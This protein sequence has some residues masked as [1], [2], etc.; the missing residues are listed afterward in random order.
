MEV[1][2]A[3]VGCVCGKIKGNY[4]IENPAYW[5]Q[6]SIAGGGDDQKDKEERTRK[7]YFRKQKSIPESAGEFHHARKTVWKIL[8]DPYSP[9]YKRNTSQ[10]QPVLV[11]VGPI[12]EEMRGKRKSS[13][14]NALL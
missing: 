13:R 7:K 9:A 3:E 14:G 4:L 12:I 2:S 6:I 5:R 1:N 10:L 11:S 8:V